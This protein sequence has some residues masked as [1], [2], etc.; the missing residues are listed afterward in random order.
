MTSIAVTPNGEYAIS[1][2][3][4]RTLQVWNLKSRQFMHALEGHSDL[5]NVVVITADGRLAVSASADHSLRVW[6]IESGDCIAAFCG[7]GPMLR[8][9]VAPDGRTIVA[10][11]KSGRGHLLRL[12]DLEFTP[13]ASS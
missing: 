7:E 5:V 2:S 13:A 6:E 1:V 8:C 9:V 3:A 4:S 10:R 11:D 12:E